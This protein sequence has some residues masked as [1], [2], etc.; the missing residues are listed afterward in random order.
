M[1]HHYFLQLK[2]IIKAIKTK[3]FQKIQEINRSILKTIYKNLSINLIAPSKLKMDVESSS[4]L[5][6]GE[7]E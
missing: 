3:N 2:N 7:E 6:S 4:S 5:S 1:Y